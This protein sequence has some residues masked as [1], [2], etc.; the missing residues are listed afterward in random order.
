MAHGDIFKITQYTAKKYNLKNEIQDVSVSKG[1]NIFSEY[2]SI[3]LALSRAPMSSAA[4]LPV[5]SFDSQVDVIRSPRPEA[6]VTHSSARSGVYHLF[7]YARFS[8][9]FYRVSLPEN[10]ASIPSLPCTHRMTHL[11]LFLCED[12]ASLF[13]I[14][15]KWWCTNTQGICNQVTECQTTGGSDPAFIVYVETW[16]TDFCQHFYFFSPDM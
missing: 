12:A 4:R 16:I 6:T 7:A 3:N 11:C 15:D 13:K 9:R 10:L 1:Q 2:Q 8:L 14:I 5:N